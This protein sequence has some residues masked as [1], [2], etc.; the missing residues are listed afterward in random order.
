M[1]SCVLLD[2]ESMA[3]LKR[4]FSKIIPSGWK[5]YG[6]HMTIKLGALGGDLKEYLGRKVELEVTK[7]GISEKVIAVGVSGFYSKNKNPHIT[8]AVDV[9]NGGKPK[10]SNLIPSEYWSDYKLNKKLNGTVVEM[11]EKNVKINES[12]HP[13]DA[14]TD[15][16]SI[17][18]VINNRRDIAT[19]IPNNL[20]Q[21]Q[22]YKKIINNHGLNY[23]VVNKPSK[24]SLSIWVIYRDADRAKKLVEYMK[25]HEGFLSDYTPEE[26]WYVGK[27]L[28]YDDNSIMEYIQ[29]RYGII[30]NPH[31]GLRDSLDESKQI[32]NIKELP[33]Y[34]D[35]INQGGKI[36]QVGGAVR[37]SFL[38]KES[39][40]L[41][42]LISNIKPDELEAILKKYGKVDF[43][44]ASF[45]VIKFTPPNGE[46]VDIAL[47]R[48]EKRVGSGHKGF[49]VTSDH[50]LPIEKDLER[51]DFT[52]NSIAKDN[53]DNLIDP[54]GGVSDIN[55]KLI[56]LTNPVA[57]SEDPLRMIRAIQ[58]ASRFNFTI[59][60]N[61]FKAIKDNSHK[62]SEISKE[63]LL[64]EFDKIVK[65]GEPKIGVELLIES[66]LYLNIF[67]VNFSGNI[68]AFDYVKTMSEFIYWLI[69]SITDQ[70]DLYYKQIL[71]G[72]DQTTKEI[73]ALAYLYQNVKND[74]T[75]AEKR[76]L[77][78]NIYKM[79]KS[80]IN[81][82]FVYA[83]LDD[84]YDDFN[85]GKYPKTIKN[86]DINGND[87]MKLG[88]NGQNI[89]KAINSVLNAVY[90]DQI[91]NNKAEII[92]YLK[93][94]KTK[95]NESAKKHNRVIFF[96]FDGTL[97]DSPQPETG[98]AKW[99]EFYNKPYPHLGWWSK[100]ESLDLNVFDIKVIKSIKA[101]YDEY[102][103]NP[104]DHVVLITNRVS[105]LKDNILDVL[106]KHNIS[107]EYHLFGDTKLNKGQRIL[108]LMKEKYPNIKEIIFYDDDIKNI[109][110]VNDALIDSDI[111]YETHLI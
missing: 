43:V 100:P 59:E 94:S 37:D 91:N 93:N 44:G 48:T 10:D 84:V 96:D 58:F 83:Y 102:M 34:N 57:F 72:D 49:E 65:K 97:V 21:A 110:D 82:N 86:L 61:T 98:K 5:W 35:V 105:A 36:Y 68:D 51:R 64:I 74:L 3:F 60:P 99:S 15:D 1:Y 23:I 14:Y 29:K 9:D 12:I 40:D 26:A 53:D 42:I 54:F 89:G 22:K 50:T 70:P 52:M 41:D 69:E 56:R 30:Y 81:S 28:E 76:W 33:F 32:L 55:K 80:M 27:L 25:N 109:N 38:G 13:S 31:L 79:S 39:K 85:S 47:P 16:N 111:Y 106:N 7:L 17:N 19:V 67:G 46:E 87:I 71:K 95:L 11:N 92:R 107:F 2:N 63:R 78:F 18:T 4:E 90:S 101:Q 103:R 66:G 45:G 24:P 6:H 77:Y 8:L 73:S 104:D 62:I 108:K 20:N 75:L 88:I